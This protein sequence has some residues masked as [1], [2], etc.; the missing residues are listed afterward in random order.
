MRQ[1][2]SIVIPTYSGAFDL[3]R[4][5]DSALVQTSEYSKTAILIP[6]QNHVKEMEIAI[7][8]FLSLKLSDLSS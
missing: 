3:K 7:T 4:M 1:L 6:N 5:F 2:F 8:F